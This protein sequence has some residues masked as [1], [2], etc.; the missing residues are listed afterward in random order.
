MVPLY[1]LM[2]LAVVVGYNIQAIASYIT[3]WYMKATK[4][5]SETLCIGIAIAVY[6]IVSLIMMYVA[7]SLDKKTANKH[8]ELK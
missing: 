2:L 6:V 3:T 5:L 1:L 8:E 7:Y 4:S